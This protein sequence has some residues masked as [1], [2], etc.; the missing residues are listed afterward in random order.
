MPYKADIDQNNPSFLPGKCGKLSRYVHNLMSY[1][2][3]LAV[4]SWQENGRI[5]VFKG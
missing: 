5:F 1:M 4:E 3:C 2:T